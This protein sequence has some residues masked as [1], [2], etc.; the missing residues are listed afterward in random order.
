MVANACNKTCLMCSVCPAHCC[1][2]QV[3][4]EQTLAHLLRIQ[5]RVDRIL[6]LD[7]AQHDVDTAIQAAQGSSRH[8]TATAVLLPQQAPRVNFTSAG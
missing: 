6:S 5:R 8:K 3:I 1:L 7:A 2:L 4:A